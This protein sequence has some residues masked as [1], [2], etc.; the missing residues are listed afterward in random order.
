MSERTSYAPGTPCW[1]D[2]GTP[3]VEAAA[4]FYG[5]LLG[6]EVPE[7]PNSAEM[8]GYRRAKKNG[9]DV[10]GVMP[11]MQEGQPPAWSTYVA[12]E[13]ADATTAAVKAAGGTVLAEPMDVM[14]LGRMAIFADPT[15]AAFGIWQ[16]GTFAGAELVNEYGAFGWNELGT[17]DT[18]SAREFYAAVFGWGFEEQD[19]GEMGT[20]TTWKAGEAMVGGMFDVTG[21]VPDEVPAHWL[22]YFTVEDLD[23]SL[24]KVKSGG[25]D[26]KN[27][28]IE[29]PVGRFAVVGDQF[30]AVFAVMQP[31][32]E[33]LA[34]AP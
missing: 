29:I 15:G 18:A 21:V 28:P 26:V 23:A 11:L 34:E 25:G 22:T 27:G 33:T 9:K 16:P 20:Y 19:M 1:V 4:G 3:D 24:E 5:A 6:W 17:R 8:G 30:G 2:L 14:E 13:D 12:V 32:E 10:A 31:S 7:L